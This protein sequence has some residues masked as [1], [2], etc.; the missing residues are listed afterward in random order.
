MII[1]K[2]TMREIYNGS[3]GHFDSFYDKYGKLYCIGADEELK[4]DIVLSLM[5]H[6]GAIDIPAAMKIFVNATHQF[7]FGKKKPVQDK[8][9]IEYL[10]G[11]TYWESPQLIVCKQEFS[12]IKNSQNYESKT[13]IQKLKNLQIVRDRYEK[14]GLL[15]EKSRR[16]LLKKID[17]SISSIRDYIKRSV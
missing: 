16:I 3:E 11:S 15:K 4:L 17:D 12:E 13:Q 1:I 8:K 10:K 5:V 7:N 14:N 2:T 6:T 9:A